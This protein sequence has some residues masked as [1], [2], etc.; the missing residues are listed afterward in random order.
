MR[1]LR[2]RRPRITKGNL[3]RQ[4]YKAISERHEEVCAYRPDPPRD[5]ELPEFYRRVACWGDESG[6]DGEEEAEAEEGEDDEVDEADGDSGCHDAW[7]ERAQGE[8]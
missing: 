1:D 8:L 3:K 5:N 6:V 7:V 2:P 4:R